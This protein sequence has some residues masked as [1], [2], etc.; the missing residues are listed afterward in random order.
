MVSFNLCSSVSR[1]CGVQIDRVMHT[2]PVSAKQQQAHEAQL[3]PRQHISRGAAGLL[4]W[5]SEPLLLQA[6]ADAA[7]GGVWN[8]SL[9]LQHFV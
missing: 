4:P 7:D 8:K 2:R 6:V 5:H 1:W 9:P 3:P